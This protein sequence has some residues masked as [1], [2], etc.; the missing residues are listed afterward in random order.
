MDSSESLNRLS[1]YRPEACSGL[2][3]GCVDQCSVSGLVRGVTSTHTSLPS[4]LSRIC[5]PKVAKADWMSRRRGMSASSPGSMAW[6]AARCRAV[7]SQLV[8]L[9]ADV[10][11][12]LPHAVE[13]ALDVGDGLH[14]VGDA[15]EA[16]GE[17]AVEILIGEIQ[18][19]FFLH[20]VGQGLDQGRQVVEQQVGIGRQ[21]PGAAPVDAVFL[22]HGADDGGEGQ[23]QRGAAGLRR[24]GAGVVDAPAFLV[25]P[26]RICHSLAPSKSSATWGPSKTMRDR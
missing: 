2:T 20:A 11:E 21:R 19:D 16:L 14:Q 7:V 4:S 13:V 15:A 25:S 23:R 1:R 9:G 12:R 18:G 3:G 5:R 22:P 26:D 8:H 17:E 24:G 6:P 10:L